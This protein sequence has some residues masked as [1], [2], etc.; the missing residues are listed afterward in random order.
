MRRTERE[1]ENNTTGEGK[2]YNMNKHQDIESSIL[3]HF[4]WRII[5]FLGKTGK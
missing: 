2:D 4:H 1:G 3:D 5:S